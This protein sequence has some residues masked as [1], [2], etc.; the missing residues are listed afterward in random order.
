MLCL[1]WTACVTRNPAMYAFNLELT[2]AQL[3][4]MG[5]SV[6][7]LAFSGNPEKGRCSRYVIASEYWEVNPYSDP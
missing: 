4:Y 5:F 1:T 2:V 7:R 3:V 6:G